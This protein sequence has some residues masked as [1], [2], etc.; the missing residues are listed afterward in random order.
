M[1]ADCRSNSSNTTCQHNTSEITQPD[2]V[3]EGKQ[4]CA[5][6]SESVGSVCFW[7]SWIR[8]RNYHQAK[9]V[10]KTLIPTI[11]CFLFDFFIFGK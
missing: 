2:A 3:I 7:A 6:G 1:V 8:I 10:R 4:C 5:S 9:I 11:L